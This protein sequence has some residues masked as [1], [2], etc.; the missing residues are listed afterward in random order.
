[1][2]GVP[3]AVF[4]LQVCVDFQVCDSVGRISLPPNAGPTLA[5]HRAESDALEL[6]AGSRQA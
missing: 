4:P 1:M 5:G 2:S 6:F 3:P